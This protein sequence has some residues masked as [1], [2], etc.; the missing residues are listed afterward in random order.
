[1][2]MGY[3]ANYADVMEDK[4]IKKLCPNTFQGLVTAIKMDEYAGG[5][6]DDFAQLLNTQEIEPDSEAHIA[7]DQLK[8][9]FKRATGLELILCYHDCDEYGDRYDEVNGHFWHIDGV[10]DLSEAGKKFQDKIK[11]KFYVTFG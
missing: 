3:G 7:Y 5:D 11:R 10:Y 6:L 1:M 9:A 8:L 4:N 2:G